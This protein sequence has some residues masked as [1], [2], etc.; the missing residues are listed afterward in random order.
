MGDRAL[1]GRAA[2]VTG[3]ASGI[4]YAIALAMADAG[5]S[6]AIGSLLE[7][8]AD[9]GALTHRPSSAELQGAEAAIRALGA[10]CH[11][12]PLDVRSTESV[13]RFHAEATAR[14]GTI[15]VL[16]N[17][18]GIGG[19]EAI[20]G[21]DERTWLATIDVNL[22]GAFRTIRCCMPEMIEQGW[23]RIVN[24]AS[25]AANVG[26]PE[27]GAYCASKAGL[28]GLT[29]CV[30]LEGAPHGITCNA[31]NPG[32]VDTASTR[33]SFED[34][35]RRE[36][37]DQTLES[38]NAEWAKG[39]PQGRLIQPEEIAALAVFLCTDRAFGISTENITVSGGTLW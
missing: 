33:L 36:G 35:K 8:G 23:G 15:G 18:A 1:T 34:W 28:L 19:S 7:D 6:V 26:Y 37:L 16:V 30:G 38:Y 14:L 22:N 25:T 27:S 12:G 21:H 4:G 13:E 3:G 29:R 2:M 17:A 39:Q 10:D 20:A 32:Q 31:I 9:P 11:A 24:I 5:A